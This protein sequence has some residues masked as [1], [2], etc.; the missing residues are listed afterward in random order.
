MSDRLGPLIALVTDSD[1][2]RLRVVMDRDLSRI[3]ATERDELNGWTTDSLR[4][5]VLIH[6]TLD[7]LD[8]DLIEIGQTMEC[9]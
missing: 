7:A 3:V 2:Q 8:D 1:L 6:L 5:G 9:R 4:L